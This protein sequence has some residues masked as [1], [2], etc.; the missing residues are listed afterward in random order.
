M[1]PL[2]STMESLH[3]DRL[4]FELG[5]SHNTILLATSTGHD[6]SFVLFNEE[7]IFPQVNKLGTQ[8]NKIRSDMVMYEAIGGG[9]AFSVG[10]I[11]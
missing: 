11:N 8:T 6:D 9:T 2:N 3:S 4:D 10:S 7:L 5:S 1:K